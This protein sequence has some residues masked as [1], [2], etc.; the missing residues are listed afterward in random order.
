MAHVLDYQNISTKLLGSLPKTR[1][2]DVLSR[3]YGL[4]LDTYET[5]DA[6]GKR[7]GI[8]RER[9]RQI[10]RAALK[11]LSQ[12][13]A[14]EVSG[15]NKKLTSILEKE[16]KLVPL[17]KLASKLGAT[18]KEVSYINFLAHVAPDLGVIDDNRQFDTTVYLHDAFTSSKL[19]ELSQE[20][21]DAF[22][23]HGQPAKLTEI[24]GHLKS[25]LSLQSI[26]NL[27]SVTK[28][29]ANFESSWGLRAW[30]RVNPRSIRDRAY[31][32]LHKHTQPLH[33][34]D[35]ASH[36][37]TI[38]PSGR[39]VTTQAVHNELIKDERF[40]LIGRGIYALADWGYSAGTVADIIRE[41]L[42]KE[43]PLH[44]DE[45]V[46]RVL[47]K[48]QVKTTTIALNLQEK[49]YFLRVSKAVYKLKG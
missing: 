26:E 4:G 6:V 30:P 24:T 27:A 22:K 18:S 36:I 12:T 11:R 2:V 34:S 21:V 7:Y 25:K 10:E 37:D 42:S 19:S 14:S 3:R 28:A 9:V 23:N 20:L 29:L 8:T 40:V 35:I 44:K 47:Q 32:A 46:K 41:V 38:T 5:L 31:L 16:G 17:A 15:L 49:E 33:Y 13:A 48:R 43:Q 39:K 1:D 45:I